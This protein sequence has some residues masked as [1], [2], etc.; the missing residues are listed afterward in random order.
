VRVERRFQE[1]KNR[2]ESITRDEVREDL[3]KRD[4]QDMNRSLAPLKPAVD[5]VIIDT[6]RLSLDRV[7]EKI[8]G[9]I[10]RKR[11]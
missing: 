10:G 3:I 9:K 6:T 5:A 4:E 11:D 8:L 2:G 7:I 1:R